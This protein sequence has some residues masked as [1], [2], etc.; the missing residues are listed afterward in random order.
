VK[1]GAIPQIGL[2]TWALTGDPGAE[3]I[4]SALGAGYRHIDTAQSYD[5]EANVGDAIARSGLARDEVFVT[6]K[7]AGA[8]FPRLADSL[9]ESLD[10]LRMDQVDL[11]LIHWPAPNDAVPVASYMAD[12]ARARDDGLTRLIG[13]S[14]FTR[15][16]LDEAI[17]TV[18]E[19]ATNQVEIHPFM[20][21]RV[22]A[23]HCRERGVP[24]TA[25]LPLARSEVADDPVIRDIAQAHEATP[26]QVSLAFLM[27]RGHIVIPKS[28]DPSRQRLNL[29]ATGLRLTEDEMERMAGL[30]RG[31]RL[32]DPGT[33]PDWD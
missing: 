23:A 25:Y 18:G 22:L 6:T 12:L 19:I 11:A 8:N 21:N 20:Q 27:A 26:A 2:G 15:R 17:D 13:V 30:D 9:R 33:A 14:N 24:L 7:I 5:T 1:Q 31:Q 4:L 29:A 28:A 32:V 10:R 3:A 16:L